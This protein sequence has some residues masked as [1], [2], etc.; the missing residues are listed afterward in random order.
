M[1]EFFKLLACKMEK[2]RSKMAPKATPSTRTVPLPLAESI[3]KLH[4]AGFDIVDVNYANLDR[5]GVDDATVL[6]HFRSALQTALRIGVKPVTLHAPWEN[7]FLMYLGKGIDK[8]INEARILLDIAYSYGVEVIVFHPF[9]AQRLGEH[10]VLWFNKRFFAGLAE[11][12][13]TEG[14]SVVAVENAEKA[15][16]WTSI[17]SV[18]SLVN[19]ISSKKLTVCIDTGHAHL[20]GYSLLRIDNIIPSSMPP[21]CLHVHDNH[22]NRDEHCIPG[23]GTIN[24]AEAR[25]AKTLLKAQY[26]VAE[27]DCSGNPNSCVEKARLATRLVEIIFGST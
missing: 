20:N 6:S 17:E 19:S 23:C 8:A 13:E 16:P 24:W 25:E 9:S 27:V 11:Y 3:E 21:I 7:Y 5:A 12:A 22:G 14:L 10:R 1:V 26:A 15:K 18:V 2:G 4:A